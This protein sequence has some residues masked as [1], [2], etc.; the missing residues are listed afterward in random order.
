MYPSPDP[1]SI[2]YLEMAGK[3]P[4]T[5]KKDVLQRSGK[6]GERLDERLESRLEKRL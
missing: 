1:I 2:D 6:K 5:V 4:S 3:Q